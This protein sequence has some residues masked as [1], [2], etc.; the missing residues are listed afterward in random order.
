MASRTIFS[1]YVHRLIGSDKRFKAL[2]LTLKHD[3]IKLL[4]MV[5]LCPLPYSLSN[6]A[7][8]T[9]PSLNPLSFA[10]ATAITSPKLLV[11]VFIGSR[12][13]ALAN[14]GGKWDA[15][16]KAV[17]YGSILVGAVVGSLTAWFIYQKYLYLCQGRALANL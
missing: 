7:L 2:S 6:G 14:S 15:K 3:G 8:A 11:H 1:G 10:L 4:C 12:I 5:R 16:T 9:V 13:A 17:N